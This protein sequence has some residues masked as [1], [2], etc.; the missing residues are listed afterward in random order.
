MNIKRTCIYHDCKCKSKHLPRI[1]NKRSN[2]IGYDFEDR[3]LHKQCIK[4]LFQ[5]RDGLCVF[6]KLASNKKD[7]RAY[8]LEL[9]TLCERYDLPYEEPTYE[10][11]L[12]MLNK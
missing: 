4:E 3:L 8:E 7:R 1:G 12:Q 9:R 2:G 11:H 6:I 5:I 10:E